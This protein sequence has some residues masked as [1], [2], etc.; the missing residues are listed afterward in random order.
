MIKKLFVVL[1]SLSIFPTFFFHKPRYFQLA[2][3]MTDTIVTFPQVQW[4]TGGKFKLSSPCWDEIWAR[5]LIHLDELNKKFVSCM[6]EHGGH[7]VVTEVVE[8]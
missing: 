6:A 7:M 8:N 1:S 4:G 5:R 3:R 2:S